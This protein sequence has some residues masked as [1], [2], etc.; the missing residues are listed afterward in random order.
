MKFY[1]REY[2]VLD[3]IYIPKRLLIRKNGGIKGIED[4]L[5]R[6]ARDKVFP[7]I[8]VCN[9]R[10]LKYLIDFLQELDKSANSFCAYQKR[11]TILKRIKI[12]IVTHRLSSGY[13]N[14]FAPF[15][16]EMPR[17]IEI[18]TNNRIYDGLVSFRVK[19]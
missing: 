8:M 19:I 17:I 9:E 11:Q 18:K 4:V 5:E 7:D 6:L 2:R 3:V 14:K 13:I 1:Y 12:W 16:N 15:V 10:T